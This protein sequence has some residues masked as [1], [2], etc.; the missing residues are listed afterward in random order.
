M[1][2]ASIAEIPIVD[3]EDV[4]AS[5]PTALVDL[6]QKAVA[7]SQDELALAVGAGKHVVMAGR[8]VPKPFHLL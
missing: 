5:G 3:V 4:C 8:G 6:A 1:L 7:S 2:E